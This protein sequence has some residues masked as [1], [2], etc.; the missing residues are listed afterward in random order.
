[1]KNKIVLVTGANSGMG[2]A[3]AARLADMGAKVVMLCR[4]RSRGEQALNELMLVPGRDFDLMICDLGKKKSIQ[5]FVSDFKEKYDHLDVL[6]NSAGV[7]TLDRQETADHMELQFGVNHI[8]HFMLTMLLLDWVEKSE[9]GRIVVLSSGAHKVGRIHFNDYNL[10]KGYNVIKSY[11]Q[12][13][14]ANLLFVRELSRR[15]QEKGSRVIVNAAHPGAVA[16]DLGVDRKTEF[17]R[18]VVRLLKPFF[19]TPEQGARTAIFLATDPSVA[20]TTGLY[21]YKCKPSGTSVRSRDMKTANELFRLSESICGIQ[22]KF[23]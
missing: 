11:S 23:D 15:L 17:G 7:I 14:L 22:F 18:S 4:N 3:T 12:S 5:D 21:F 1:M 10:N 13:K 19:Q 9:E 20:H 8:G 2:K 16:T 6:I